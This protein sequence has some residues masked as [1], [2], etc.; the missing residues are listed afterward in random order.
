MPTLFAKVFIAQT[1]HLSATAFRVLPYLF[2]SLPP[3]TAVI[4]L[5]LPPEPLR[6]LSYTSVSHTAFW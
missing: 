5:Y 1:M 2:I 6:Q 3:H 4:I